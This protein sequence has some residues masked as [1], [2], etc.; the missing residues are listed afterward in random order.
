M[1]GFTR[2][3]HALTDALGFSSSRNSLAPGKSL[4]KSGG[5]RSALHRRK[6]ERDA[7]DGEDE[8]ARRASCNCSTFID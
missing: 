1:D 8:E 5:S 6:A 7:D 2:D 3:E 4:G